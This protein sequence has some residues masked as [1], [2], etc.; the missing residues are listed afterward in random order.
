MNPFKKKP[1][2]ETDAKP[3]PEGTSGDPSTPPA[4]DK[5]D[6]APA[7]EP[8]DTP[9]KSAS[10]PAG[11]ET[12]GKGGGTSAPLTPN[13]GVPDVK[14]HEEP[15]AKKEP[16]ADKEKLP[17]EADKAP[18]KEQPKGLPSLATMTKAE[19]EAAAKDPMNNPHIQRLA[20]AVHGLAKIVQEHH[21]KLGAVGVP[22]QSQTTQGMNTPPKPGMPGQTGQMRPGTGQMKPGMGAMGAGKMP[23]RQMMQPAGGRPGMPNSGM[24]M[25]GQGMGPT[26]GAQPPMTPTLALEQIREMMIIIEASTTGRIPRQAAAM[27]ISTGFGLPPEVASQMVSGEGP[28]AASPE[29]ALNALSPTDDPDAVMINPEEEELEEGL[30]EGEGEFEEEEDELEPVEGEEEEEFGSKWALKKFD[31]DDSDDAARVED[32]LRRL[33]AERDQVNTRIDAL[34]YATS[35]IVEAW[36]D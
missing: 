30:E 2:D 31:A 35:T 16:E 27:L 29:E 5:P 36:E 7:S 32:I 12:K 34:M 18:A 6:L 3:A 15:G 9:S 1:E 28:A 25:P 13:Q 22:G 21:A 17:K 10:K 8:T 20:S 19:A 33:K 23:G 14:P 24:G 11:G 4:E 26:T